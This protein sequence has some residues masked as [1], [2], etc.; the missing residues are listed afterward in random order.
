[1]HDAQLVEQFLI[2]TRKTEKQAILRNGTTLRR[3]FRDANSAPPTRRGRFGA[4]TFRR[5][6]SNL[7]V[8]VIF[9]RGSKPIFDI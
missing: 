4:G 1:M 3:R 2:Y 6:V 9:Y 5:S 8:T 7:T